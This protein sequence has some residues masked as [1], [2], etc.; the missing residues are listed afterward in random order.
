MLPTLRTTSRA[1]KVL[2]GTDET[3]RPG[4]PLLAV[5]LFLRVY[6]NHQDFLTGRMAGFGRC[7][8]RCVVGLKRLFP[9]AEVR[10]MRNAVAVENF[11]SLEI[12][13]TGKSTWIQSLAVVEDLGVFDS[14][15]A[16]FRTHR[17]AVHGVKRFLYKTFA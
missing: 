14:P 6:K 17:Q 15:D 8:C 9:G 5:A 1:T 16:L 13:W 3:F 2:F 12:E 4:L 11:A 7:D 10:F